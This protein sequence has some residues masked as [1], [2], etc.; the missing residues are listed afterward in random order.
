MRPRANLAAAAPVRERR[1]GLRAV[2]AAVTRLSAP[3][4]TRRGGGVLAR[5]KAEWPGIV[6]AEWAER[7]WPAALGRDHAL[8]VH[9]AASAALELQHRAPLVLDRITLYF[10]RVVATR[11]VLV[12]GPLPLPPRGRA[13]AL[14]PLAPAEA[15]QLAARLEPIADPALRAALMRLGHAVIGQEGGAPSASVARPIRTL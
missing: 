1:Y 2:G 9:V 10:G 5:L 12:Q 3:I 13:P 7:A 4:I 14:R 6:G 8:R 15:A 11:L